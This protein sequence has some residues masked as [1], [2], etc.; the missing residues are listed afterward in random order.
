MSSKN[1]TK[2]DGRSCLVREEQ[3]P[4]ASGKKAIAAHVILIAGYDYEGVRS[5]GDKAT[6]AKPFSVQV[7]HGL[8]YLLA[9]EWNSPYV[10]ELT[11]FPKGKHDDQVDASVI[12]FNEVALGERKGVKRVKVKGTH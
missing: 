11:M 7:E 1:T 10:S 12:A 2:Q 3:E 4:G 8:V 6:K 5:T 9:G